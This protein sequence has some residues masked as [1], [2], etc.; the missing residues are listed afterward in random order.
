MYIRTDREVNVFTRLNKL[1]KKV[2][3]SRAKKIS[4][5]VC[6]SCGVEF[7]RG[8]YIH[9]RLNNKYKHF[10]EKC[11]SG[12][13]YV[14][15]ENRRKKIVFGTKSIDSLG[16]IVVKL[17][18]SEFYP[19]KKNQTTVHI[20]EHIKVIQDNIGRKLF[21]DEVIHHIDGNKLNNEL[22][23]LDICSKQQHNACHAASES[24]IFE[25]YKRGIVGYDE[26]NKRYYLK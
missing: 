8:S 1:G 22:S 17:P 7:H 21:P 24:I 18:V 25:L 2:K 14:G 26:N 5:F 13:S 12:P 11:K 3:Y 20:R 19:G 6:D 9:Q 4:V 15:I 16:Y 10:C 23:N